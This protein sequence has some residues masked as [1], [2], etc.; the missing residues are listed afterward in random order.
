MA[1]RKSTKGRKTQ[2]TQ[3]TKEE[4]KMVDVDVV[5]SRDRRLTV[6]VGTSSD[7][8]KAKVGLSL[9]E[10]IKEDADVLEIADKIFEE[11]IKK[12][13]EQFEA[14]VEKTEQYDDVEEEDEEDEDASEGGGEDEEEIEDEDED[15]IDESDIRKMKKAELLELI[16]EEDL[17]I[18]VSDFKKIAD[19]REAVVEAL[20]E[21]EGE[22]E[23][24]DWKDDEWEDE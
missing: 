2:K 4:N 10:N 13:G 3:T 14:L 12:L 20:F 1:I 11:L 9:S 15:E 7:F 5:F 6:S 21:E 8:G 16:E 18:D 17:D 19:L 22:D 23:D 24:P